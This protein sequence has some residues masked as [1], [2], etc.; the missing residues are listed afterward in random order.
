MATDSA[1]NMKMRFFKYHF[2]LHLIDVCLLLGKKSAG[3][4]DL[5]VL[6]YNTGMMLKERQVMVQC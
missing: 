1:N 3:L 5:S 6:S 4:S 2:H